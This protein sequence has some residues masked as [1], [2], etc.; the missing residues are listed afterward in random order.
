M[1][2]AW[3][4]VNIQSLQIH[5]NSDDA[6]KFKLGSQRIPTKEWSGIRRN[7][8]FN[9][10]IT[11]KVGSSPVAMAQISSPNYSNIESH[12]TTLYEILT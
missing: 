7:P 5:G 12:L 3:A 10:A 6:L 8:F 11:V 9:E 1:V 4:L 2:F